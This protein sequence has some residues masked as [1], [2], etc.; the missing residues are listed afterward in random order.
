RLLDLHTDD[1]CDQVT[2]RAV[3]CT[4]QGSAQLSE[5]DLATA[6]AALGDG[7]AAAEQA[8]LNCPQLEC[9]AKLALLHA[10]RG[11]L[12]RAEK[13]ARAAL[14]L[15]PCTGRCRLVSTAYAYLSL[16]LAHYHADRLDDAERYLELAA[17]P[18]E[19][20][21]GRPVSVGLVSVEPESVE[22]E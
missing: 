3:A 14:A 19:P 18:G 17:G 10:V 16:A 11:E 4:A 15:P 22:S 9:T 12:R 13:S 2:V 6:A 20:T 5:G 1:V 7:L 8:G 21:L